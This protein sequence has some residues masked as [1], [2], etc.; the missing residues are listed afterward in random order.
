M[1]SRKV[2]SKRARDALHSTA[3]VPIFLLSELNASA[4]MI[5]PALPTA[6]EMP[7]AKAL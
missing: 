4:A 2:E 5:A 6:A 3:G 1:W 7:C